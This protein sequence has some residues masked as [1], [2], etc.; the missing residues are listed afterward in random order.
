MNSW[1]KRLGAAV[2]TL[3]AVAVLAFGGNAAYASATLNLCDPGQPGYV[4]ECP[5][6]DWQSCNSTC[7]TV[8]G[9][10]SA[11]NECGGGCCICALR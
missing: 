7:E 9:P 8:Y 4:G 2:I 11:G 6:L 1:T 5:P 10:D 3:V